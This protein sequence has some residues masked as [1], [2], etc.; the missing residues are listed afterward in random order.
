MLN[1]STVALLSLAAGSTLAA[2]GRV[3]RQTEGGLNTAAKAFGKLYFGSATDNGELTDTE[4]KAILSD[5]NEFGQITPGNAMKWDTIESSRGN[6]NYANGDEIVDLAEENGQ[7]LRCH[8]LVWHNQ[9]PSWVSDGGFDNATLIEILQNHIT[10]EVTHYKGK[11]YAWDVV[12]EAISDD[13]G[14]P[15]RDDIFLSTI[16]E[17]YIPIAFAA[18]A[19]ADPDAKLYYNDYSIEAPG[20]KSTAAQDIVKLVQSYGVKIDGVGLQDHLIVGSTP[21]LEDQVANMKAFTDLGVEV[22][23]T[24][25]D[26]RAE[27]PEANQYQEQQAEDYA[28]TIQACNEVEE[29]VGVTIWDWTDKY[30]WVPGVFPGTGGALP[31]DEDFVKKPAYDAI[32]NAYGGASSGSSN[33]NVTASAPAVS[34]VA[35]SVS[36]PLST[37]VSIPLSTGVSKNST[38]APSSSVIEVE[39]EASG[40]AECEIVCLYK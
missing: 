16:G 37:G 10:E 34:N 19:A 15:L 4:Y 17:A 33:S 3:R 8:T 5:S 36:I 11:C 23:I 13:E 28:T 20:A 39:P 22:A 32:L 14:A 6:F 30:S 2:P 26:I 7:I 24:E 25:L 35:S 38:T 31:W 1:I 27:N 21:S 12:N 40:E 18:A 9:L 29:C